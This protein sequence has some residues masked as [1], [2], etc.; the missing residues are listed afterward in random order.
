MGCGRGWGKV[1][2]NES[3]PKNTKWPIKGCL[4]SPSGCAVVLSMAFLVGNAIFFCIGMS[5]EIEKELYE[6]NYKTSPS[7]V[8][9]KLD[10]YYVNDPFLRNWHYRG[11]LFIFDPATNSWQEIADYRILAK[12]SDRMTIYSDTK[13]WVIFDRASLLMTNDGGGTWFWSYQN[14]DENGFDLS[15]IWGVNF[16]SNDIGV[17]RGNDRGGGDITLHT[18]DGGI[19]WTLEEEAPS[20]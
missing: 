13:F 9:L 16:T 10:C 2:D 6:T 11:E 15:R 5:T 14:Q 1:S 18:T 7:G 17:L 12:C 3:K 8:Q 19:T 20:D 4:K